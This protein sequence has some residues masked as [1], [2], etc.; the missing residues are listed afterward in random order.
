MVREDRTEIS[1]REQGQ[2]TTECD[3]WKEPAMI[4]GL[5]WNAEFTYRRTVMETRIVGSGEI[6]RV[7][8]ECRQWPT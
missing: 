8:R 5:D 4:C 7:P 1:A 3:F 2:L 6:E